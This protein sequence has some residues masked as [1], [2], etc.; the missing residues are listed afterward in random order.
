MIFLN[1][2]NLNVFDL[3]VIARRNENIGLT[4]EIEEIISNDHKF[5]KEFSASRILYGINTGFGPMA[6]YHVDDHKQ[7][8]LQYNLIRSHSSGYGP[9]LVQEESK[10]VLVARLN[11]L[12][13]G[14]SGVDL[15]M[16]QLMVEM[17]NR[18]IIPL[19]PSHGGVGA[20][21][22]LVQLAHLAL[23]M[24]G[25]SEVYY[26]NEVQKSS[27]AFQK[28]N[29]TTL[30][31]SLREGIALLN[32]TSAMTGLASLN[33]CKLTV[34]LEWMIVFSSMI[35]EIVEAFDDHFSEQLNQVKKHKGQ[36]EIAKLVRGILKDSQ[37]IRSRTNHWNKEATHDYF[38]E[39]VQEYYSIR[40][41][42]QILG[43]IYDT[44]YSSMEVVNNELNSTSDNPITDI[45]SQ[46]VYHGGNFHGDYIALEMDKLKLITT[47]L[48]LLS[49]RQLNFLLNP[50]INQKL[51]PFVN[52][53]TPGLNFGLQGMQFTA[54]S[55]AAENQTLSASSYIHSIS[56]NNDN[57]DIVSMGFNAARIARDLIQNTFKII[58]IEAI[59]VIHAVEAM[60]Q[61]PKL[62]SFNKKIF[63]NLKSKFPLIQN[64]RPTY[65]DQQE[66]VN[67]LQNNKPGLIAEF[68]SKLSR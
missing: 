47:K 4:N 27:L 64:D 31:I 60:K 35:N 65:I 40:C 50:R 45:E 54:T 20:S 3:E 17:C 13:K 48:S 8:D 43:P 30:K 61:E 24:I 22:D 26:K 52:L 44:L 15:S 41:I 42:P 66:L 12:L 28:E 57:Q 51:P 10:A 9:W 53:A 56:C 11:S 67:Y 1:G 25:E 14:H 32:G 37:L 21:G 68:K 19:I 34:A 29:L 23:A 36:Q 55:T 16:I 18:N 7:I 58:G 46:N 5:L 62:S 59:A 33:I 63:N 49:E 38:K 2:G 39:K 6:Q